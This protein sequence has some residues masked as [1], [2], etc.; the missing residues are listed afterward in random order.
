[1]YS[2]IVDNPGLLA[3][4]ENTRKALAFSV[5]EVEKEAAPDP[6]EKNR[7]AVNELLGIVGGLA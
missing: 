2:L 4:L 3:N 5:V 7:S 6:A 1:M